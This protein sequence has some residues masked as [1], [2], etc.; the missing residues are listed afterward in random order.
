MK[1]TFFTLA[2][3]GVNFSLSLITYCSFNCKNPK[4]AASRIKEWKTEDFSLFLFNGKALIKTDQL[5]KQFSL[6]IHQPLKLFYNEPILKQYWLSEKSPFLLIWKKYVSSQPETIS[7]LTFHS[8]SMLE[9]N[10]K[11]I[12]L[13]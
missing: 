11:Q 12:S 2:S 6:P 10:E 8:H 5:L 1:S 13:Y 4:L 7:K 3:F 9:K